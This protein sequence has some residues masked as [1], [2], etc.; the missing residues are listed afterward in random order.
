VLRVLESTGQANLK[1]PE[2]LKFLLAPVLVQGRA[3]Q[4]RFY[5]IF[6]RYW[7]ELQ[8]P[9]EMPAAEVEAEKQRPNWLRWLFVALVLGGLVWAAFELGKKTPPPL[10]VYFEHP[11]NVTLGD[12][13][14]F[15]NLSANIDSSA[16]RWEIS[17]PKNGQLLANDS[18]SYELDYVVNEV[19]DN[20]DRVVKLSYLKSIDPKTNQPISHVSSFHILCKD[21]PV[22]EIL[23]P[24]EIRTN[25]V[26]R[27][28]AKLADAKNVQLSWDFGDS[29]TAT[30][31]NVSHPF[32][33]SG[34]FEVHLTA[35]R[36]GLAGDC[37]VTKFHRISVGRD[38]AYLT[39]KILVRDQVDA[40]VN[41]SWGTWILMGLLGLAIIWFWVKWAARKA[42]LPPDEPD[43]DLTAAAERFKAVDKGPYFI[44]FR[45]QEGYVRMEPLFYRLAD[46]LRQR[47]EGIRKNMDVSAS[48]KKTIAEGGFPNLLSK[49]DAVPTEYLFLI[50]EQ[51]AGSHQSKLYTFLVDFLRK[52]EVLGEVFYFKT[53]PIRFWNNQYPEGINA[54]Q[55][56]RLFPLNR[57]IV[58]GDGHGLLDPHQTQK[59]GAPGIRSD[60]FDYF[61]QWKQRM[62]LTPM[63]VIS[64][65]YRE[66][67]LHNLFAIFPSDTEGLGEAIKFLERGMD[68]ED[69]PTYTSWCE[70][71]LEG[72]RE[73]DLNYRRWR[74]AADHRDYL[75]AY[76][77][78]YRWVCALAVYPK[79]D[80]NIT[81]AIGRALSPLGVD[82][83]YDNLL[84]ISRIPWLLTGDLSPRLRKELLS[85]LDNPWDEPKAEPLARA[86]VQEELKAVE[87]LVVGGHANQEH[88]INLALQN[89]AVTPDDPEAQRIVRELLALQL[90]TPKHLAELN[91]SVERHVQQRGFG[92]MNQKVQQ[93]F[94]GNFPPQAPDIQAFLEEN[95]PEKPEP[96]KKPFF[97]NDFWWACATTLAYLLIF[98]FVWSFGATDQLAKWANVQFE[99]G[100]CKEQY[101]Y[102]YF[103]KKECVADSA[104]LYNN[105][106][107]DAYLDAFK[108][109]SDSLQR[110]D[111]EMAASFLSA[112][113]NFQLALGQ[114]PDYELAKANLGSLYFN[115]GRVI[116]ETMLDGLDLSA[117]GPVSPNIIW[118]AALPPFRKALAFE[119]TT[120][121]A[122][123]G[124]G[125]THFFAERQDSALYYYQAL[126]QRSDSLYFDSLQTYPHLQSLL[127]RNVEGILERI[128]VT[129]TDVQT[130]RPLRDVMVISKKTRGQTDP[131][132]KIYLEIPM[133]EKR[134][135]DITKTGYLPLVREIQPTAYNLTFT[136]QMRPQ[137]AKK[138]LDTDGDGVP[139]RID[140]CPKEPGDPKNAGCPIIET[141]KSETSGDNSPQ[142][143]PTQT[144]KEPEMVFVKGGIFRMG[145][146]EKRDGDCRDDEIP[147]L[148]VTLPDFSIGKY[149]VTNEDYAV[150]LNEYG[151]TKV[152]DG[153]NK[154]QTMVY[155]DDRGI[156]FRSQGDI[157]KAY[158]E[159]QEGYERHPVVNVSWIGAVAYTEWLSKKTNKKYRLPTEAEWE[160]AARGGIQSQDFRYSGG[161]EIADVAWHKGNSSNRTHPRGSRKANEIGIFD[162]SGNVWEW[163]SD[164]Y[165]ETY[166]KDFEGA[167]AYNPNGPTS[168]N[169]RVVRSGSWRDS[170]SNCRNA[171]RGWD[172]TAIPLDGIG[173]RVAKDEYRSSGK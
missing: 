15:K 8:Q 47:Q 160:Y 141:L 21:P 58:L 93:S 78:L 75:S 167:N 66:G 163:C 16:L 62:L 111:L 4:E 146:D 52:R 99:P 85:D 72:R 23:A 30:G 157:T 108:K 86:A 150:F 34:L 116:Y 115:Q 71:L 92:E 153:S 95:K 3:E 172:Y 41:F 152:K 109:D 132:G 63:P 104:V 10:K 50:D 113:K 145:C 159:P 65:T 143:Q 135:Y 101:L 129:V 1:S 64:W 140:K 14:H 158:F 59:A 46:V 70:R 24:Q 17:H 130:G 20:H 32:P 18:Q 67:A 11:L 103:L 144:F 126:M 84:I 5:E 136:V 169:L 151:M 168:G 49:A 22:V 87:A 148:N 94:M 118:D 165:S 131:S 154:G 137:V 133:G 97:T 89:F 40:I 128:T 29:T 2:K 102:A 164:W 42:P 36:T 68:G 127:A 61:R 112:E 106:G 28:E 55:L 48:L 155:E 45:P 80:W 69:L 33:K 83:N 39:A 134:V 19:D 73:P 149:E 139:D 53:E 37:T 57:L 60:A 173:F 96:P 43:E 120:L 105:A 162:M 121:D 31:N 7:E 79:P 147:V 110:S 56:H 54:D 9:W 170:A 122:L 107:V 98:W 161:N 88:Q 90:A 138:E 156:A 114:R 171:Y 25:G 82:V 125:L 100:G 44:P 38:K 26:A 123:H 6:D 117:A 166:Y 77:T 12:T 124:I 76:P 35:T 27:F 91:Q 142:Q 74:T 13:I 119:H 81:L 51:S